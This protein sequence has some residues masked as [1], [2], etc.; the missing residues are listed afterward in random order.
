[1]TSTK[2]GEAVS[3]ARAKLKQCTDAQL[4]EGLAMIR[5]KLRSTAGEHKEHEALVMLKTLTFNEMARRCVA[6]F[7]RVH[8]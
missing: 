8:A 2:A 6:D 7:S 4:T 3:A 5:A 1:L